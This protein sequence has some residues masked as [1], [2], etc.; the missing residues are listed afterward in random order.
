MCIETAGSRWR[1]KEPG[2]MKITQKL[3]ASLK[4]F[5]KVKVTYFSRLTKILSVINKTTTIDTTGVS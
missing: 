2:K 3:K 1:T 4:G 5:E